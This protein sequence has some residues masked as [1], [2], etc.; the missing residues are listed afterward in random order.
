MEKK[1]L[2]FG[3]GDGGHT[4]QNK[5]GLSTWGPVKDK[6]PGFPWESVD[7]LDGSI[8][9]NRRVHDHPDGR[10]HVTGG[11]SPDHFWFAF[12]WWDRSGDHR[13]ASNSG[14]YVTGFGTPVKETYFAIAKIAF[15]YACKQWPNVVSR[16]LFP[17]VIEEHTI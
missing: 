1:A 17:L 2:Y 16:Q 8:L 7:W 15:D 14:F 10:V 13:G 3:F 4:L 9:K 5:D 11:G 6:Y 12:V